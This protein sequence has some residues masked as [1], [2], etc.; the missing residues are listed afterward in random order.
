MKKVSFS[1]ATSCTSS[2]LGRRWEASRDCYS[3][4][5]LPNTVCSRR[6]IKQGFFLAVSE[7][8]TEEL[9]RKDTCTSSRSDF[10]VN[11]DNRWLMALGCKAL[12]GVYRHR[13][14]MRVGNIESWHRRSESS[15]TGIVSVLSG[16]KRSVA[17]R[18]RY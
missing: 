13:H 12:E 17:A 10:R 11:A 2:T 1:S 7:F 16:A 9:S 3:C 14:G 15:V 4:P 18:V 8:V 6:G 5:R